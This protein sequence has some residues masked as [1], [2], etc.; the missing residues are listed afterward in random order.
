MG[1]VHKLL[2]AKIQ[3]FRP[4]PP[5]RNGVC[6]V[7]PY[8][9]NKSQTPP[10]TLCNPWTAPRPDKISIF[11]FEHGFRLNSKNLNPPKNMP[12]LHGVENSLIEFS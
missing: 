8:D 9:H 1:A 11:R 6:T 4:L 3:I 5:L 10:Q 2:T 12:T 7:L